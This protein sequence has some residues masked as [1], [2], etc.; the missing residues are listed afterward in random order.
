[1]VAGRTL[2]EADTP[3]TP[4]AVVVNRTFAR[5]YLGDRPVGVRIPRISGPRAGWLRFADQNAEWEVVGVVE[6]MRQDVGAPP[7]AEMFASFKQAVMGANPGFDPI[8][9]VRTAADPIAY[10]STLRRLV[11]EQAPGLALD[12]V[13]TLEDRVMTSLAKPRL[14]AVVLVL[15]AAFAVLIAGVGLFGVMSFSVG[16][17][18]R[19]IGV[20]SALGAQPRDIV[21]LVLR[22]AF[23]IVG[24]GVAIGLTSAA[25]GSRLLTAFLYGVSP[26]DVLTFVGVAAIVVLAAAIS[27][28]LPA[29]RAASVD[30]LTALRA[31]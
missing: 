5:Q 7:Q 16:Q 17:R 24:A 25:A 31:G 9:V 11:Q 15:F 28:L 13:M 4:P 27:C 1:V 14:Y 26:Y 22:Q 12:S 8:L 20:R 19:E 3:A 23:W 10:A 21:A 2:T 30:P 6:E 18:T 29:R